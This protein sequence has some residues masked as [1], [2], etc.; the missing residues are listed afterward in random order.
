MA[1][2]SGRGPLVVRFTHKAAHKTQI[3]G[4]P[5]RLNA[6]AT[7]EFIC[8]ADCREQAV[9]RQFCL[10][11]QQE[12]AFQASATLVWVMEGVPLALQ[13]RVSALVW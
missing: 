5:D 11:N 8:N 10:G 6:E 13:P 1:T 7:D 12:V 9:L 3:S 4:S 2:L